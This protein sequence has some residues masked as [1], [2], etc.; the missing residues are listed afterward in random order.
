M[1]A[2]RGLMRWLL[3]TLVLALPS[4]VM[5]S[6]SAQ[7]GQRVVELTLL[8]DRRASPTLQQQWI[9]ALQD[10]KADRVTVRTAGRPKPSIEESKFRGAKIVQVNGVIDQRKIRL[11][12]KSFTISQTSAI[13][14]YLESLRADGA[15]EALAEKMAF[16][17][18]AEQL[19]AFHEQMNMVVD[20]STSGLTP[21]QTIK[22]LLEKMPVPHRKVA[23]NGRDDALQNLAP[24]S[25]IAIPELSGMTVGTALAITLRSQG[26]VFRPMRK[27]GRAVELLIENESQSKESWPAGW[28]VEAAP[29][30]A[31]PKMFERIPLAVYD[32]PMT[33]VINAIKSRMDV[34]FLIDPKCRIDGDGNPVDL[35]QRR[36]TFESK[37][38]SYSLALSKILTQHRPRLQQEI[39][40]DERGNLF[41]WITPQ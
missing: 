29:V 26:Q 3:V 17:L 23:D 2:D 38:T 28:P 16:G 6:A 35:S 36:V 11:P 30:V 25:E 21:P 13:A 4:I 12:G 19:V 1:M 15:N 5:P 31:M 33:D 24:S 27:Q 32:T 18:S 10:V 7:T 8:T 37:K 41:V 39:R 22:Y 9:E 34:P 40:Q 14:D 20:R